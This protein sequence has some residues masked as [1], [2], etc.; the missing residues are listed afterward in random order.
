MVDFI[1]NNENEVLI[2]MPAGK[3]Y[4]TNPGVL[5]PQAGQKGFTCWFY[6]MQLVRPTRY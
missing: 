1:T 6:S 5:K 2:K 3:S 4:I